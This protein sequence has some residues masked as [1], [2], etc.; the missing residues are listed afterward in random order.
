MVAER[1]HLEHNVYMERGMICPHKYILGFGQTKWNLNL[2]MNPFPT[3]SMRD[4]ET[5][6]VYGSKR[7]LDG[8]NISK[9]QVYVQSCIHTCDGLG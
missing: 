3:L 5:K 4:V 7:V 2:D 6:L 1:T 9:T 8:A